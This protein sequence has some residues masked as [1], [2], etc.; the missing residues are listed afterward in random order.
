[1]TMVRHQSSFAAGIVLTAGEL[2]EIAWVVPRDAG[3]GAGYAGAG[4][5]MPDREKQTVRA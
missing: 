1:M 4:M 5:A 2:A 3:A